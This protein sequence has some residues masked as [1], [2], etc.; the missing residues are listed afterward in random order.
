[1][2]ASVPAAAEPSPS[3]VL[4]GTEAVGDIDATAI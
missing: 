1:M 4:V 3:V 2:V